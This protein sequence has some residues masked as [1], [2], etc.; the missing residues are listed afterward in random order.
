[1]SD[2]FVEHVGL[3]HC[4]HAEERR[5]IEVQGGAMRYSDAS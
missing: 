4:V 5:H 1:L 3:A 2:A